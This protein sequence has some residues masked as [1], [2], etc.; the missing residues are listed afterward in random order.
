MTSRRVLID[1]EDFNRR[2]GVAALLR[3]DCLDL[4]EVPRRPNAALLVGVVFALLIAAASAGTAFVTGRAPDGW[5]DDG[6]LVLDRETGA[7]FLALGQ[8]LRPVP[9]L[10]GALLAGGRSE[11]VLVP[12]EEVVRAPLG[13]PLPG[14][15]LP[16]RPPALPP[17]PTGFSACLGGH[18][19]V[20]VFAGTPRG[21]A[22]PQDGLL[23]R[24]VGAK[25]VV[26]LAG[27]RA[28]PLSRPALASLGYFPTQVRE[29]PRAWLDLVPRGAPLTRLEPQARRGKGKGVR[30]VGKS[31][32]VVAA[33]Q[34]GRRF[35]VEAGVVRP[36][37]NRTSELLAPPPVRNV[38]DAVL[39]AA[40]AGP[41]AGVV[42]APAQPPAVPAPE[43]VVVP[44]VR[45]SDGLVTLLEQARDNE[46]RPPPARRFPVAGGPELTMTWHFR[47][48][49]GALVGPLDL[50]Q[51]R[52]VGSPPVAGTGGI[53]VVAD[54]IGYEVA[55]LPALGA[56]GYRREQT[57]LLPVT[58]LALLERGA[59]LSTL[60]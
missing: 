54:G 53:R 18:D 44:C 36:L 11:P 26:L 19:M 25:E 58:W 15:G 20:D 23:V 56:L 22:L 8:T 52:P 48:G 57:V 30:G 13:P 43:S 10:T 49:E 33:A 28:H 45:S 41:P 39:L 14:A 50:D 24:P 6:T 4:E 31:G 1:A 35:L 27:R 9:T 38:P 60:R 29:V 12:H 7:R 5:R 55:D 3:G 2:R 51:P 21:G 34:S 16:E 42:D 40:P 17:S 59:P 46:T 37:A 32:Q 47:P